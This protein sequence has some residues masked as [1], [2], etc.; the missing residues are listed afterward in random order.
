[1]HAL[2]SVKFLLNTDIINNGCIIYSSNLSVNLEITLVGSR[3]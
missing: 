2:V 1:M 3:C